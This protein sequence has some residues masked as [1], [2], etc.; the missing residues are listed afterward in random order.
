M[1]DRTFKEYVDGLDKK[2]LIAAMDRVNRDR[3]EDCYQYMKEV[4]ET[5]YNKYGLSDVVVNRDEETESTFINVKDEEIADELAEVNDEDDSDDS[6]I[7]VS[8]IDKENL[9][10]EI[11]D[12][13][14]KLHDKSYCEIKVIHDQYPSLKIIQEREKYYVSYFKCPGLSELSLNEASVKK[15]LKAY[16]KDNDSWQSVYLRELKSVAAAAKVNRT[17]YKYSKIFAAVVSVVLFLSAA[18]PE[19]SFV[20]NMYFKDIE[21]VIGIFSLTFFLGFLDELILIFNGNYKFVGFRTS[22]YVLAVSGAAIGFVI[23][24]YY[25]LFR[26]LI[27]I[28]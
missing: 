2:G 21:R 13:F 28:I 4:L 17:F 10:S 18:I 26:L 7:N 15:I 1:I 9:N 19:L 11:S 3:Y 12:I 16:L 23:Y 20:H 25:D 6:V 14:R 24:F 8:G 27:R 22:L 5:K